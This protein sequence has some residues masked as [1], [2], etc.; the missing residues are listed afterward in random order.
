VVTLILIFFVVLTRV[1]DEAN[2]QEFR[3]GEMIKSINEVLKVRKKVNSYS[4]NHDRKQNADSTNR[5][6]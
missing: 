1:L 6:R 3:L 5:L 2:K 4:I